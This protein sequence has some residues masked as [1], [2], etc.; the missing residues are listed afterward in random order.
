MGIAL[1]VSARW[2]RG[3]LSEGVVL[4]VP[5]QGSVPN[6]F[7]IKDTHTNRQSVE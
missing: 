7:A 3:L 6:C 4:H 5:R 2:V 1:L